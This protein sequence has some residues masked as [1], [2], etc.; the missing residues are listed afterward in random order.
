[1][2]TLG[3]LSSISKVF[4]PAHST[5]MPHAGATLILLNLLAW[6][7]SSESPAAF[8]KF[9][10]TCGDVLIAAMSD[11]PTFHHLT[12][13]CHTIPATTDHVHCST[14]LSR[15]TTILAS[16]P[17]NF[18]LSTCFAEHAPHSHVL[19]TSSHPMTWSVQ[20]YIVL[21]NNLLRHYTVLYSFNGPELCVIQTYMN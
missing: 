5:F 17:L 3:V 1:M 19:D 10:G 2:S 13:R 20:L 21:P 18:L 4:S 11:H 15:A 16:E 9:T 8:T 14:P 7:Y 6:N 12:S